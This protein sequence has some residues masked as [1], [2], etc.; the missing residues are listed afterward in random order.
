MFYISALEGAVD[1]AKIEAFLTVAATG[2]FTDAADKLFISQ[3]SLSK[4]MAQIERE[5]GVKLFKKTRNGVE[6]TQAGF[7]FYSYAR[8]TLPEYQNAIAR[9][10]MYGESSTYPLRIGALPLI[11]EYGFADSFSS[12]WV[13]NPH[14]QFE[15]YE[16]SQA[17][18]LDKLDRN[19]IELAILR[20]DILDSNKYSFIQLVHDV[21]VVVCSRRHPLAQ[22]ESVD[23]EDLRNEQFILLE[24]KSD[25]TTL[26]RLACKQAGFAPNAPLHHSRH[27][28][29]MKAVQNNMG[30][31]ALPKRLA[32]TYLASDIAIVTFSSPINSSLGIAWLSSEPTTPVMKDFVTYICDD[33]HVDPPPHKTS[34]R[35]FAI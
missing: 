20:G 32:S 2:K 17:D 4:Q 24:E 26:F 35:G 14:I 23:I 31:T 3:S 25:V 19:K 21:L 28:M 33:Y 12:Y 27:R 6:L 30:I 29:L 7:D 10:K 5:L 8:K 34:A 22:L 1:F 16:R 13:R 15:Y 11:E 9:L 18:L